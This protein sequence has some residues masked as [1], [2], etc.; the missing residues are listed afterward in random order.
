MKKMFFCI[1]PLM[2]VI[3][4]CASSGGAAATAAETNT[5]SAGMD[6]DAAIREAA[7]QT[8]ENLPGGTQVALVSVASSSVQL[9]EYII[10]RLE[11]ALVNGK[12]L[13]VVDRANLDKVR[14][15]QGFQLSGEVDDNSAKN[16]GKLLGA[17]AIVTG[18]FADLGDV[19]TLTLKA[20][21]IET[22][23]VAVSYPADI[24][25]STRI[26]TMLAS[27][28]AAGTRIS[29]TGGN[30]QHA[31]QHIPVAPV[32]PLQPEAPVP[33]AQPKPDPAP[34]PAPKTYKVGD[35][36][37]AG[38]IVFYD[39]G[40]SMNGWRYLEAAPADI[41]GVWQWS[42]SSD[43]VS[44]IVDGIGNG[45]RNTQ[46]IVEFLNQKGETMKAAQVADAYEQSGYNDW[47][48]PSKD[49]LDLLYKNL[50]AKGL[51]GFQSGRYWTSSPG[52]YNR[53][54]STICQRFSDGVQQ[55][56]DKGTSMYVRAV[57]QF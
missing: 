41:P 18:A 23:T 42:T 20:I 7:V 14:E 3:M 49:E 44:G 24:A 11:A 48:L 53:Y 27:G 1:I 9:S 8:G 52:I 32:A 26:A 25:K 38:G 47:F 37:P 36:G 40:F 21:N 35:T 34:P 12:K 13:T 46:I 16:I 22:A 5:N 30:W 17:G 56:A 57:R 31:T 6:L 55:E 45:K 4:G 19:Y 50:K 54:S 10:S 33:A 15:E 29:Q 2:L 39:M 43:S 51:G 28:G